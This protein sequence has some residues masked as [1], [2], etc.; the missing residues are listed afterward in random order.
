M[1][2]AG[3][4]GAGGGSATSRAVTSLEGRIIA[5]ASAQ[6]TSFPL[7]TEGLPYINLRCVQV[8]NTGVGL[9]ATV[10]LLGS[11]RPL[12][13]AAGTIKADQALYFTLTTF[14]MPAGGVTVT[15][16]TMHWAVSKV[17]VRM[18]GAAAAV[19]DTAIA[20]TLSAD[21]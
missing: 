2:R 15:M 21:A 12:G 13:L 20:F 18:T 19:G 16:P 3:S 6:A 7:L 9:G 11:V 4:Y 8:G 1:A 5:A 14:I 17:A 10:V